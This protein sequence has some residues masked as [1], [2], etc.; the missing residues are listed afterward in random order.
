MLCFHLKFVV[1]IIAMF[2]AHF[3]IYGIYMYVCGIAKELQSDAS[4]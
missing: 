3:N 2:S 1:F 4:G